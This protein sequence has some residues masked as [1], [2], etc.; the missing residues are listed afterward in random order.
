MM[1]FLLT[2]VIVAVFL[3]CMMAF[4]YDSL[5]EKDVLREWLKEHM[6]NSES[7]YEPVME[8]VKKHSE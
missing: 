6:A 7:S 2:L 3:P 4:N 1:K 8:V 5:P